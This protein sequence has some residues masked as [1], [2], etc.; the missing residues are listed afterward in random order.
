MASKQQGVRTN[1]ARP[2][3][4]PYKA[5]QVATDV[6]RAQNEIAK[7]AC[8][9]EMLAR[10]DDGWA[11]QVI[12]ILRLGDTVGAIQALQNVRSLQAT[13]KFATALPDAVNL[14]SG[15]A[16]RLPSSSI[17]GSAMSCPLRCG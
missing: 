16:T 5:R 1:P 13:R 7:N 17:L 2:Q 9:L 4:W 8:Q 12:E 14:S 3:P 11:A 6:L 10:S 15:S